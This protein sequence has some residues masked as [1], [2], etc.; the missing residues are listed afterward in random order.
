MYMSQTILTQTLVTGGEG[1]GAGRE[2]SKGGKE[3]LLFRHSYLSRLGLFRQVWLYMI[4]LNM[5]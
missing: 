5:I 3:I 2:R 4:V 1:G